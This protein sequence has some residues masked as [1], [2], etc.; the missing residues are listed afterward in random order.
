MQSVLR[1]TGLPLD[2]SNISI[3]DGTGRGAITFEFDDDGTPGSSTIESAEALSVSGTGT[4]T[5]S[6]NYLGTKYR[7][8]LIEIDGDST[9]DSF[10]WSVDD[11]A[12]FN[13]SKLVPSGLVYNLSLGVTVQFTDQISYSKGDRWR[14]KAYPNNEIVE[15]AGGY[16]CPTPGTNKEEFGSCDQSCK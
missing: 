15:V 13:D 14:I 8:Y 4:L 1:G 12:N 9:T 5:S 6:G 11:G 2:G 3:T 7:E 10:R 16:L